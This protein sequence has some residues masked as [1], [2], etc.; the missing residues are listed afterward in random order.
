ME[1]ITIKD[2]SFRISIPH[3]EIQERVKVLADR[4]NKDFAG[5]K[6]LFVGVLNG[7]FMFMADLLK[8]INLECELSF[9]KVASYHGTSSTGNVKELV[10]LTEGIRDRYVIVVEDIVDSGITID[11]IYRDLQSRNPAQVKIA[12][13]L[14]KPEAYKKEVPIDYYAL[15]IPNDFIVGYGLDYDGFGRNLKDI[16]TVID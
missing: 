1:A 16:Y 15:S 12:T 8:E 10:G 2:R 9:V 4:I 13:L 7:S 6:P 14:F 11:H 5:K 3:T